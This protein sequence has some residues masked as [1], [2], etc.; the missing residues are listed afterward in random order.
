MNSGTQE[1]REV[2]ET[3]D[4]PDDTLTQQDATDPNSQSA[5]AEA[6][7]MEANTTFHDLKQHVGVKHWVMQREKRF[8]FKKK[9]DSSRAKDDNMSHGD[10][11]SSESDN[12][13]DLQDGIRLVR[14]SKR[15]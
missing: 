14:R 8:I 5:K 10:D 11:Q 6:G 12:E 13:E 15:K 7:D 3:R 1:L 4:D 2:N 9:I